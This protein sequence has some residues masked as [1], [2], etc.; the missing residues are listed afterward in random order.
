MQLVLAMISLKTARLL[1]KNQTLARSFK[2]G[3]RVI[4]N[5]AQVAY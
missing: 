3:V 4:V 2:N 1:N 5:Y